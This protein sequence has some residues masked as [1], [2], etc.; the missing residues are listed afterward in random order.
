MALPSI[1]R[2]SYLDVLFGDGESPEVFTQICGLT[3][4]DFSKQANTSEHFIADCADPE[5]VADRFLIVTGQQATISGE[6]RY[7]RAQR[8]DLEALFGLP[9]NYRF[10]MSEP[11]ADNIENGYYG[12]SF[13]MTAL[14]FSGG[15]ASDGNYA[16]V[17][18]T[19]E[20][21]GP[22]VWTDAV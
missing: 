5:D 15:D 4:K 10:K 13:I 11:A 19:F 16:A 6:G 1:V 18:V 21:T 3:T 17:S 2:G 20:S 7:N 8:A 9:N 14:S 22:V 12:G